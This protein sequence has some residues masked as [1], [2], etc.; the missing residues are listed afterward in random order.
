MA[1]KTVRINKF[2]IGSLKIIAINN[3]ND[4]PMASVFKK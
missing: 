3:G 1:V 4:F 2:T